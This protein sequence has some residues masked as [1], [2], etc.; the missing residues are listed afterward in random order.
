[1]SF[2]TVYI[3]MKLELVVMT[4]VFAVC[5]DW[6]H[7]T[8]AGQTWREVPFFILSSVYPRNSQNSTWVGVEHLYWMKVCLYVYLDVFFSIILCPSMADCGCVGFCTYVC[9]H[10]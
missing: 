7:S 10:W 2:S 3:G 9:F 6:T 8:L 1:M 4:T 5:L